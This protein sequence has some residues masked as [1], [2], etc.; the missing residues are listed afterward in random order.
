MPKLLTFSLGGKEP[1]KDGE[2]KDGQSIGGPLPGIGNAVSKSSASGF[3]SVPGPLPMPPAASF[4]G[5]VGVVGKSS[6]SAPTSAPAVFTK[7]GGPP[8]AKSSPSDGAGFEQVLVSK[9][10]PAVKGSPSTTVSKAAP[11]AE[12]QEPPLAPWRRSNPGAPPLQGMDAGVFPS[13]GAPP[14][15][16]M[17]FDGGMGGMV[18]KSGMASAVSKASVMAA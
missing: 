14:A 9:G 17:G 11:G 2:S 15:K 7:G 5:A 13:K 18:A 6:A 16:G 8:P 12:A 10:A 1:S 3:P 4:P